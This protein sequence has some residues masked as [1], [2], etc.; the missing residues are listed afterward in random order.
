MSASSLRV[1]ALTSGPGSRRFESATAP[2]LARQSVSETGVNGCSDSAAD[3]QGRRSLWQLDVTRLAGAYPSPRNSY[4]TSIDSLTARS[5]SRRY[6]DLDI[7]WRRLYAHLPG[8]R[9]R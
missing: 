1:R 8:V 2:L 3:E 6:R 4:T 9:V 7:A 5:S